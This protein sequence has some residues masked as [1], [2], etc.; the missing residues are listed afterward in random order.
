MCV[1]KRNKDL[2][3]SQSRIPFLQ[4]VAF[5]ARRQANGFVALRPDW[6][7]SG[8]PTFCLVGSYLLISLGLRSGAME[9]RRGLRPSIQRPG[10]TS[11]SILL[12]TNRNYRFYRYYRFW[13]PSPVHPEKPKTTP[14]RTNHYP[15]SHLSELKAR[16]PRPERSGLFACRRRMVRA[17][18]VTGVGRFV[19]KKQA[20]YT[21]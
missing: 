2:W 13:N 15:V 3:T 5:I 14:Q 11:I 10:E 19:Q 9:Q 20:C 4:R 21:C 16:K 12:L 17:R 1:A 8:R 18:V 6:P 7:F